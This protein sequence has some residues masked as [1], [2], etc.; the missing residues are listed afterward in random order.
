M[1]LIEFSKLLDHYKQPI[2]I[3]LPRDVAMQPITYDVYK[4]GTP[5]PEQS[6]AQ[7]VEEAIGEVTEWIKD[8]KSP[9]ILAGVELARFGLGNE[10]VKFAEKTNIPIATTLLS[11]SVVGEKHPQ[12]LGVY[13][14]D[15][16]MA[17]VQDAVEESDCLLM[18]GVLITDMTLSFMPTKFKK[19]NTV[20]LNIDKLKVKNH[21]YTEILFPDFCNALFEQG[22]NISKKEAHVP[23]PKIN[24]GFSPTDEKITTA[25]FFSKINSILDENMAIIADIGDSLFGAIDL[26]VHHKNTFLAPAFYTSMGTA[27]PG[28][29]GVQL[30]QPDIRPL[31]LVGDGAFQMSCTE[32]STIVR[33]KLNPIVFVLNNDGYTTE[34]F[35]LD[36]DFNDIAPWKYHEITQMIGGGTGVE[37]TTEEELDSAIASALESEELFIINV[38]VDKM[39]ISPALKRM[40][41]GLSKRV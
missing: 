8:S 16:S 21:E 2:Y 5:V 35:L 9:V 10:L 17:Q 39:D 13:A 41:E 15:T 29:L 37:A 25:R 22:K 18:L 12:F 3:E 30:A 40:A 26:V 28:A 38:I 19:R 1:R 33:N 7:N 6:D 27:I 4:Q 32:L 20:C 24:I 36:G 31:V 14:G 11:K 23:S 34:R